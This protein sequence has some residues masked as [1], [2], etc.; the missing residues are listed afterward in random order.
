VRAL[1]PKFLWLMAAT[2][3]SDIMRLADL[4]AEGR[5]VSIDRGREDVLP[6]VDLRVGH[7]SHTWGSQFVTI[8]NDSRRE[9]EDVW[10]MAG[11]L[12]YSYDNIAGPDSASPQYTPIGLAQC[13]QA[14][15]ILATDAM[16][17]LVVG[18]TRRVNPV[19][20]EA[21]SQ[22]YP[23]RV[24]RHGRRIIELALADGQASL[25]A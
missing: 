25:V 4:A 9:S 17:K 20:E 23:H 10:V 16:V 19:H 15:L 22:V 7:D 12:V 3:P 13:C 18:E 2:N 14:N 11:D 8:R 24:S 21:L 1:D 6:G 5:L